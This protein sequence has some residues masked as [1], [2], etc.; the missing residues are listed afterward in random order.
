M[1]EAEHVD[2]KPFIRPLRH[3]KPKHWSSKAN[4][5]YYREAFGLGVKQVF[6]KMLET[7][8][9]QMYYYKDFP[10]LTPNSLY[11]KFAQARKYLLDHLDPDGK[12]EDFNQ[13]IC[14]EK[15]T[16][17]GIRLSIR[18]EVL[19]SM[20]AGGSDFVTKELVTE[21]MGWRD[22]LATYL[23]EGQLGIPFIASNLCLDE[24]DQRDIE[25]MLSG[26]GDSVVY[27]ITERE[28]KVVKQ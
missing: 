11:L 12:Y 20:I 6:D 15:I 25:I 4:A 28:V 18:K 5:P 23:E 10:D 14:V 16:G 17:V 26:L 27:R 13:C 24:N 19:S 9:D 3:N 22:K 2:N 7:Q 8:R 1:S 21:Q